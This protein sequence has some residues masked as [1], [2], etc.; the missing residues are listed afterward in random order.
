MNNKALIIADDFTGSNDTGVQLRKKGLDVE[1]LLFPTE[2][3][4][5]HS[6]VLDTESR[7]LPP[8]EAYQ[9]VKALTTK[10]AQNNDFQFIYKK[11]DSTLRGNIAKEIQAVM[12]VTQPD[13]III[14]PAFPKIKRTTKNGRHYL[15]GKPLMETE[16]ANDPLTPI[17]TDDIMELLKK[18]FTST[19]V[20]HSVADLAQGIWPEGLIH[21]FDIQE[22]SDLERLASIAKKRDKKQL[23]V[24]SAGLAEYLFEKPQLPT[25][26]VVGSV[27]EVSLQQMNVAEK[28]GV[29]SV[30]IDLND[31]VAENRIAKY[32]QLLEES[33]KKGD[34]ILT[35]TR[36][37][38]DYTETID[39][40]NRL[41]IPD[42]KEISRIIRESLAKI[43]ANTLKSTA[44]SGLF[45]TGGDTA[46]EVIHELQGT[47]CKILAEV[48]P[49]IV[50][51]QLL[52]GAFEGLLITTK[53]G[54][55][56]KEDSLYNSIQKMK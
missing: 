22:D 55:F 49:G 33:L 36:K 43:T 3:A 37:K 8:E 51:C 34:T 40:F 46:I 44:V 4:L 1:V 12:D 35:V 24:G 5:D 41:G 50:Q 45:L 19:I 31:L 15:D 52:G 6:V 27:S 53:A 20:L 47:G 21:I 29:L 7:I 30:T 56:G 54:A 39:L 16:I 42:K 13:E 28:N 14:A 32:S 2:E 10:V 18:D 11:I 25:L 23:F 26:S 38:N 17:W 48:E 9:K